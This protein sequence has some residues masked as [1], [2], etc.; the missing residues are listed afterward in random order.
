MAGVAASLAGAV[1][2]SWAQLA[3]ATRA[4]LLRAQ[5]LRPG[6][7]IALI[8]PSGAIYER[9]PYELTIETL[10]ALGFQVREAPNVRARYGHMAGT[11]EQRAKDVNTM[12]A[13]PSVHGILA[14]TG[15]SGANRILPLLDSPLIQ[16]NPTFIGGF[17]DVTAL[18]HAI[19]AKPGPVPCQGPAGG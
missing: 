16:R 9:A 2:S 5:R 17:S 7:T 14:V 4:P 18:I 1:P 6:N 13:D 15:G 8:N 12:F 19:P 3:A 11:P 10:Q